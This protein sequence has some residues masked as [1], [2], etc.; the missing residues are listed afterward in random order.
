MKNKPFKSLAI[1]KQVLIYKLKK[2]ERQTQDCWEI[3]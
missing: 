3:A 1:F 2:S